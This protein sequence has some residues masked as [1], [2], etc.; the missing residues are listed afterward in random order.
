MNAYRYFILRCLQLGLNQK[1]IAACLGASPNT[2]ARWL[3]RERKRY[4][5][6]KSWQ[7]VPAILTEYPV[8]S[9][10]VASALAAEKLER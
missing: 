8:V 1:R 5:V 6:H 10:I 4:G 3:E 7:I 9:E 2:M